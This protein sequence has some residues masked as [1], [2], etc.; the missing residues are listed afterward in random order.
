MTATPASTT[1]S[2]EVH[3]PVLEVQSLSVGYVRRG[4]T[5][6]VLREV[7]FCIDQG[8][9]Y[10]LVGES[11]CGKSTVAMALMNYLAENARV[12]DGSVRFQGQELLTAS[13]SALRAVR[14]DQIAMVYQE[15][16]ASL[17]PRMRVGHQV[18]EVYL[19]HQRLSK[20]RARAAAVEMLD[21]V[22]LPDPATIAKRY[23]HQLS[24]GQQQRVCIAMALATNPTLLVMDEPTTGLDATVEAEVLD[25]V[26]DLR[27]E[28]GTSV[29]LI[30]HNLGVI[31]RV[32]DRVG[33]LYAGRLVEEGATRVV[34]HAPRHPYTLGLLRCVPRA[35]MRK[36]GRRL[37]PIPGSLPTQGADLA[38]CLYRERC[39]IARDRCDATAPQM[40]AIAADHSVMCHF[41]EAVATIPDGGAGATDRR[42]IPEGPPLLVVERLRKTYRSAGVDVGAVADVSLEVRRG[43]VLG[44]VGESGS[45]KSS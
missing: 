5:V 41:H 37:E 12:T 44:I 39:P 23:P 3:E 15:V 24:G 42:A 13:Q 7:S 36:D 14:G 16:G 1:P 33:V 9:A 29:L 6:D 43:E 21:R 31:A 4:R 35:G 8:E 26:R 28:L 30:S 11:G 32:C 25:L 2:N 17:N 20:A 34:L 40:Q 27:H 45:G 38:P 19:Y 22:R 10:G 18:A